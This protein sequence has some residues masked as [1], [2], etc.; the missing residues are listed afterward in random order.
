MQTQHHKHSDV[1]EEQTRPDATDCPVQA[2]QFQQLFI[3][4]DQTG[5]SS[6]QLAWRLDIDKSGVHSPQPAVGL[7]DLPHEED[8]VQRRRRVGVAQEV[9]QQVQHIAC[10]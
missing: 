3:I 6:L 2:Q 8:H 5:T 1:I 9:H 7:H 10:S 4:G